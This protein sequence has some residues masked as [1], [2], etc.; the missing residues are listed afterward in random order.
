MRDGLPE[1]IEHHLSLAGDDCIAFFASL[2]SNF[3]ESELASVYTYLID[4][5]LKGKGCK[6]LSQLIKETDKLRDMKNLDSLIDFI[7]DPSVAEHL[8]QGEQVNI[9]VLCIKAISNYKNPKAV[10][11]L[12]YCL[13]NKYEHYRCRFAAAE[14]LGKI[15]DRVAVDSLI[16]VVSDENEKSVYVRESAAIALGMLGD[17]RAVDPFLGILEAK[18]SFL[19]KFTFLKER[20]ME[21][22]GKIHFGEDKRVLDVFVKA[23]EDPS[24][25]IRLNALE[26]IMNAAPSNAVELI[27][28]MLHDEDEAVARATVIALYNLE[29]RAELDKILDNENVPYYCKEEAKS[30]IEEYEEE[31]G[32]EE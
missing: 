14:A 29:G 21:A 3:D 9:R 30:I 20:I 23:L 11:P 22:L 16:N 15:G 26:S 25:Q 6:F 19:D 24:A 8:E 28:P 7:L 18:K 5:G 4:V 1:K 27:L 31:D 10:E 2:K 17:M 13:N 12:L 32:D